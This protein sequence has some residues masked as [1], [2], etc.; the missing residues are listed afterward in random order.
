MSFSSEFELST[1]GMVLLA[2]GH[3]D[4]SSPVKHDWGYLCRR[5]KYCFS[6]KIS[7]RCGHIGPHGEAVGAVEKV[8][9]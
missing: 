4:T 8:Q 6:R 7:Q 3:L 9:I 2:L 5:L 1:V